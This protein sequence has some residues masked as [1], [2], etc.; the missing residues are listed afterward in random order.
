MKP[1]SA[2]SRQLTRS[3]NANGEEAQ[4]LG[5]TSKE[6]AMQLDFMLQTH[7]KEAV[8][9]ATTN[10]ANDVRAGHEP[11]H[12]DLN[13]IEEQ[14]A[15]DFG[16]SILDKLHGDSSHQ[17][18]LREQR[19]NMGLPTT[20][21][22]LPNGGTFD[23]RS[24]PQ[25]GS[26]H[27]SAN[28]R[29]IP[30]DPNQQDDGGGKPAAQDLSA[31][32]S[33]K[34]RD[35]SVMQT[36]NNYSS[37]N[38]FNVSAYDIGPQSLTRP[39]PQQ[40][41]LESR[42][43]SATSFASSLTS[44]STSFSIGASDSSSFGAF[45]SVPPPRPHSAPTF[46]TPAKGSTFSNAL[47]LM[48]SPMPPTASEK[49]KNSLLQ[50]SIREAGAFQVLDNDAEVQVVPNPTAQRRVRHILNNEDTALLLI[51]QALQYKPNASIQ[52][53]AAFYDQF[54]DT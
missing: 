54:L 50:Y 43:P 41:D 4:V 45:G 21:I 46:P 20:M 39:T 31:N 52:V 9:N 33:H 3:L 53:I 1:F 38:H 16:C 23:T 5:H 15:E 7:V 34:K 13:A 17:A 32:K 25:S 22:R 47:D 42:T 27:R 37:V 2:P 51:E 29:L 10:L 30:I 24:I 36:F 48:D 18:F 44:S 40:S 49:V 11:Y 14:A 12:L 6:T 26:S 35:S 28:N 19:E 8:L